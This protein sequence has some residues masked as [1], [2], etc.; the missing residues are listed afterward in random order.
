MGKITWII[1][2]FLI[3]G[4]FMIINQN[5]L[6]IKNDS[7]DRVSFAKKFSGWVFNVGKNIK[8]LTGEA[9]KQEWLPKE[10]HDN[11]TIK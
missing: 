11:D 2:A 4:A 1:I 7:E 9:T 8:E 5:G 6:D 3:V 10:N